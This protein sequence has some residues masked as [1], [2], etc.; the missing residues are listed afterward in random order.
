M[1]QF[2]ELNLQQADAILRLGLLS[3][4]SKHLERIQTHLYGWNLSH[5]QFQLPSKLQQK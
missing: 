3:R 5:M 2:W 1:S 4:N